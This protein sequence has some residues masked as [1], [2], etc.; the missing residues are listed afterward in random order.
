[1]AVEV[2]VEK[3]VPS[4]GLVAAVLVMTVLLVL[5][6]MAVLAAGA[7]AVLEWL[8]APSATVAVQPR[9]ALMDMPTHLSTQQATR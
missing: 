5:L 7:M 3:E 2:D 9:C 4:T 6:V 8:T 1:M